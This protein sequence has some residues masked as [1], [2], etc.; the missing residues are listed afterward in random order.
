MAITRVRVKINGT[1]FNLN[2]D[3]TTGKWNGSL[4][5]PAAT[6]FNLSGGYYPV[7]IEATNDAGTVKTWEA[8]DTAWGNVLKLVVKET[9]KP[10]GIIIAPSD[11]AYTTNNKPAITFKVTDESG[12]SGVSLEEVE[13][14][15]DGDTYSCNS[16]GMTYTAITNGYQFIYM[17]QTVLLD[18]KHAITVNAKDNDGNTA[19]A[20]TATI[21]VDTVPPSL[22]VSE[23]AA[24]LITNNPVIIVSGVTNDTTSSPVMV[25]I[26]LNG[27]DQGDV[28]VGD[29]GRYAKSITL[30]EGTNTIVV[31]ATDAA[32][33]ASNVTR[34]VKLDTSIPEIKTLSLAPNPINA[35]ESI[36][37]TLEVY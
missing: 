10:V 32:G 8:T 15:I 17:P 22:T 36:T 33:K 13:L 29:D 28:T 24:G 3:S 30:T 12:G 2:Q 27:E 6:S 35:S 26:T 16:E 5:A 23:P 11:G 21:T 37:I 19:V 18:G 25:I 31:E 4:T 34:S 1:W 20:V 7:T 9:I 14:K